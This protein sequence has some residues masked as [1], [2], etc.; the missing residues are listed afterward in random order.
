MPSTLV[1]GA[2]SFVAAHIIDHLVKSGHQV[3]GLVRR[4]A[5]GEELLALHPE[6]ADSLSIATIADYSHDSSWDKLF[7][8]KK[9]DHVGCHIVNMHSQSTHTDG[10]VRLSM[11][12]HLF[13]T[14]PSF[15][16]TTVTFAL[17][18]WKA[19]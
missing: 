11:W 14:I 4:S 7:A 2:N 19:T 18:L 12:L 15:P 6:W 1:T 10:F 3:T 17:L 8:D 9:F 13:L 16:T 5:A